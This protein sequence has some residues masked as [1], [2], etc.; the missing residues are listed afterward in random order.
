VRGYNF[1]QRVRHA[2]ARGREEAVRLYHEYVATEHV[3]LGLLAQDSSV[4]L[5]VI[6]SFGVTP[7]DVKARIEQLVRS[8]RGGEIRSDVPYDSRAKKV[9]ELAMNEALIRDD[10]YVG[11]QHLLLGLIREERGIAAAVLA[12]FDIT[13]DA[14]RQRTTEVLGAGKQDDDGMEELPARRGSPAQGQMLAIATSGPGGAWMA[15]SIIEAVARD[16]A[17]AGVFAAQGI[18][19]G[20]LV[21]ALRAA[22]RPA[23]PGPAPESSAG[24]GPRA[25]PSAA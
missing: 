7:K 21:A 9:L 23:P 25:P 6:E 1:T 13:L 20:K 2:L 10:S 14:A 3:L 22:A 4:A 18:D 24:D 17:I 12:E 8:G 19:V 16:G 11:T 5:S 15:A